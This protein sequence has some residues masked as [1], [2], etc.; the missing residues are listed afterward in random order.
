MEANGVVPVVEHTN[1]ETFRD[2]V[3]TQVVSK[4]R[5]KKSE[6]RR[7]NT[8]NRKDVVGKATDPVAA[9]QVDE[10]A[11]DDA[12]EL[13][14]FIDV[15]RLCKTPESPLHRAIRNEVLISPAFHSI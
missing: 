3:S 8:R 7:K 13:A 5:L 9:K 10:E 15:R 1:Y 4:F 14:D 2:C 11:V 12:D 6:K